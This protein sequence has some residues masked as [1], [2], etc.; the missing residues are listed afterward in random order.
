MALSSTDESGEGTMIRAE[1]DEAGAGVNPYRVECKQCGYRWTTR[2]IDPACS[3]CQKKDVK[4][5]YP[6]K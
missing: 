5:L 4:W 3:K 6:I 2:A 1:N